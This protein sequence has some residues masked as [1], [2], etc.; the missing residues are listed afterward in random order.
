MYRAHE[1]HAHWV[2]TSAD[3]SALAV[4]QGVLAIGTEGGTLLLFDI[5]PSGKL[6]SGCTFRPRFIGSK[7]ICSGLIHCIVPLESNLVNF[8]PWGLESD[9][10][11]TSST[12]TPVRIMTCCDARPDQ[13]RSESSAA[14]QSAK[15]IRSRFRSNS[16]KTEDKEAKIVDIS[17]WQ[18]SSPQDKERHQRL[19]L[20][21][22]AMDTR[23]HEPFR[24]PKLS[25]VRVCPTAV[26]TTP[27]DG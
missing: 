2:Q 5:V 9:S 27:L 10:T 4:T 19:R 15:S 13:R 3:V 25:L 11:G 24:F 22:Q 8:Q 12:D 20:F 18:I 1:E 17:C 26:V 6:A 23:N 21:N 14:S 7:N 16:N